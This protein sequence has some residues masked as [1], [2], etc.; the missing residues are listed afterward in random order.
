MDKLTTIKELDKEFEAR[1]TIGDYAQAGV[2]FRWRN[3]LIIRDKIIK[4][5]T[6]IIQSNDDTEY[7]DG[8]IWCIEELRS[9]LGVEDGERI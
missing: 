7:R 4:E 5:L 6:N 8:Q 2:I 3:D 9:R 1:N